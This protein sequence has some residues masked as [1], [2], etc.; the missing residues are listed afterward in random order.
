MADVSDEEASGQSYVGK[1]GAR[2][3]RAKALG[4]AVPGRFREQPGDP[5]GGS[6]VRDRRGTRRGGWRD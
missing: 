4:Q 3:T 1:E 5:H 2:C 6:R